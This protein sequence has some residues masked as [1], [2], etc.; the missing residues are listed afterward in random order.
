MAGHALKRARFLVLH[1]L[2]SLYAF[3]ALRKTLA[4]IT[5]PI[6]QQPQ[7]GVVASPTREDSRVDADASAGG[8]R[9]FTSGKRVRRHV[10]IASPS[11][12]AF[13][14]AFHTI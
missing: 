5:P 8:Y 12:A 14:H 2:I 9:R 3:T 1:G 11:A 10:V 6:A 13:V 4:F 7:R